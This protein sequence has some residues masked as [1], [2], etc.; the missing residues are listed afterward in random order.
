MLSPM[1][2]NAI[3]ITYDFNWSLAGGYSIEGMFTAD[4]LNND[5]FIRDAEVSL[6]NFSVVQA[7]TTLWSQTGPTSGGWA[8]NYNSYPFN[9][10]YDLSQKSFKTANHFSG[11]NGQSWG[12]MWHGNPGWINREQQYCHHLRRCIRLLAGNVII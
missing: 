3:P 10:N 8:P 11:P 7:G 6:L 1:T 2:V 12:W 4:D 5:N 9:F